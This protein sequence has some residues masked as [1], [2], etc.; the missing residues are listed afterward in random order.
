M[1]DQNDGPTVSNGSQASAGAARKEKTGYV[2]GVVSICIGALGCGWSV[3]G[4][5]CCNWGAIP[6]GFMAI[7]LAV[8]SLVF[9]R[10]KTGWWGLALGIGAIVLYFIMSAAFQEAA[11]QNQQRQLDNIFHP[12]R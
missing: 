8:V 1:T 9:L 11:T 3:F 7:V 5:L 2:I 12:K 10:G 6:L 4:G